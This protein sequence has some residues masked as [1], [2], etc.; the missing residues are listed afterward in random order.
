MKRLVL[1]MALILVP[2]AAAS[3]KL[4]AIKAEWYLKGEAD[5]ALAQYGYSV[6]SIACVPSRS[7]YLT[8]TFVLSDPSGK[9]VCPK[10]SKFYIQGF[11]VVG[12]LSG[13][14][15]CKRTSKSV[16]GA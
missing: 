7:K 12:Q 16:P 3:T 11:S 5:I 13:P 9:A 4:D 15:P 8:C 1:L 10:P 14:R 6:K 2:S